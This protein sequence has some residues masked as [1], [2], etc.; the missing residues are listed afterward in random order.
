ME[1]KENRHILNVEETDDTYVVSFAKH[2]GMMESMEDEDKE[3]ME[4]RPYHDEEKDEDEKE[5][6]DKSDIVYR[7][8]DL[9]RASH[10]DEEN[11]RVRIGVSS[12]EP[13]ERDFGME[14][15]LSLIHI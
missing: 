13:V 5:R 11:R 12:E 2:E 14:I 1:Y 9:S 4:S 10:I 6:L 8:L 3:M 15:I 7:T